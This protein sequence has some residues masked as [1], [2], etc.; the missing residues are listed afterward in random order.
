MN[1]TFLVIFSATIIRSNKSSEDGIVL[2]K[3]G[4]INSDI[5]MKDFSRSRNGIRDYEVRISKSIDGMKNVLML[6][7]LRKMLIPFPLILTSHRT[8]L[9]PIN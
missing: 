2:I 5:L 8:I 7:I 6:I 4:W 9:C 3:M 1:Q